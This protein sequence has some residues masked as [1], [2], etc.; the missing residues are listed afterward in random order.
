MTQPFQPPAAAA[1]V[2]PDE[3]DLLVG[4]QIAGR[5]RSTAMGAAGIGALGLVGSL[6][7]L[8]GMPM[9]TVAYAVVSVGPVLAGAVAIAAGGLGVRTVFHSEPGVN[10]VLRRSRPVVFGLAAAAVALGVIGGVIGLT[11][12]LLMQPGSVMAPPT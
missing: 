4:N 1:P 8:T 3:D 9:P 11:S 12:V 7:P 10:A 2:E 6:V 5:A